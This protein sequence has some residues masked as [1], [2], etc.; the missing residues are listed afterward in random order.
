[1]FYAADLISQYWPWYFL[2]AQSLKSGKLPHWIPNLYTTGYP[3]LAE[4]E[5]GVLSPING[6]VLKLLPFPFSVN[7]LYFIYL[8][9][10][11]SGMYF[12]LRSLNYQKLSC[13]MGGIIFVFS[14][15]MI[16][17]Y[18]QPAI[19][20]SSA[21]LPWGMT[22]IH[23]AINHPHKLNWLP[24]IIYLQ[25]TAGHLQMTLISIS[26]YL[27]YAILLTLLLK[28]NSLLFVIHCLLFIVIGLGISAVQLLPT[29]KL[30]QIS[31]RRDWDPM[32]RFTYS[33]PPSHLITYLNPETFGISAPGDN[34]GFSQF[35]GSFW[36]FNLTIWTLPFFLSL[37]P[38]INLF[39]NSKHKEIATFYA[40]WI[41]FLLLSL[42][43]Y[44]R[45][46]WIVA[47]LPNFPF[48]APSRFLLVATFAASVLAAKGFDLLTQKFTPQKFI[49]FFVIVFSIIF[50][51]NHQLNNY[52]IT[53]FPKALITNLTNINQSILVTPLVINTQIKVNPNQFIIAFKDGLF[54][55]LLSISILFYWIRFHGS[56]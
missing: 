24:F 46:Y 51:I 29:W 28:K 6:L 41:T 9:I 31:Q 17:R 43:G 49:T 23:Q 33:L 55:S 5:T 20:F 26:G 48:R 2:V 34:Y 52:I 32:I 56:K 19:I 40:L 30:F 50:Q 18:F 47:H 8:V 27:I 13:F 54:I 38:L 45:P 39:S 14:G 11:I 3:L 4:G 12:F 7:F 22:I 10:A 16:S 44:F 42:G 53:I 37:F 36:E 35:G 15:F 25:I 21:L 1:M